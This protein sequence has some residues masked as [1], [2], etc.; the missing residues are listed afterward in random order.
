MVQRPGGQI[1][2]PGQVVLLILARRH[3]LHL[4]PFGHPG[5]ADFG[6]QMDIEFV[7]KDHGLTSA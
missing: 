1:Q 3:D 7:G 4:G 5:T 6:Q 2:G